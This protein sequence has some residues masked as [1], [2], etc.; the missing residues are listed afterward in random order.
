MHHDPAPDLSARQ[1]AEALPPISIGLRPLW[2]AAVD[3]G[4]RDSLGR[5]PGGERWIVPILGGTFWGA[6]GFESLQG[7]VLPGGADRQ[8]QRADG[9]RQ[10]Q[11]LYEMRCNDGTVLTIDNQVI[12]DETEPGKRYAMSHLRVTAPQGPHDWLNRRI[13]LGTLQPLRPALEAVLIRSYLIDSPA[14]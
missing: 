11:A 9:A 13:V 4:P 6:A 10:L 7:V 12:I 1:I 14:C 2:H 3:I 5:S 8:L